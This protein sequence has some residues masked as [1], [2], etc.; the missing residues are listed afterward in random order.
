MLK[1][2]ENPEEEKREMRV[3]WV[4]VCVVQCCEVSESS[5]A[6]AWPETDAMTTKMSTK[7]V[8]NVMWCNVM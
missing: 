1:N 8:Q 2:T 4:C 5:D 7:Q 6:S 3:V